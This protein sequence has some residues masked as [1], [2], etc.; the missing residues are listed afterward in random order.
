MDQPSSVPIYSY[1]YFT[2]KSLVENLIS[3]METL[4]NLV[5][6]HFGI[7]LSKSLMFNLLALSIHKKTAVWIN[8]IWGLQIAIHVH[9]LCMYGQAQ[10]V[11]H[12]L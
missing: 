5:M 6:C 11:R 8:L 2:L 10:V 4:K 9:V 1:M 12:S 7:S 3:G